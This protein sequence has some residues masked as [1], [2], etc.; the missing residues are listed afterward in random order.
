MKRPKPDPINLLLG[1]F[2]LPPETP[3]W[4]DEQIKSPP[5]DALFGLMCQWTEEDF[6]NSGKAAMVMPQNQ[7]DQPTGYHLQGLIADEDG[8]IPELKIVGRKTTQEV[9]ILDTI[10]S[11]HDFLLGSIADPDWANEWLLEEFSGIVTALPKIAETI[12][13][14]AARKA[15]QESQSASPFPQSATPE[16]GKLLPKPWRLLTRWQPVISRDPESGFSDVEYI[17]F[18][19]PAEIT[20]SNA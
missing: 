1:G 20:G 19:C 5:P 7:E 2:I 17:E 16:M 9:L 3:C 18:L 4:E 15:R 6:A 11:V 14:L 10:V 13:R 12:Q 8:N